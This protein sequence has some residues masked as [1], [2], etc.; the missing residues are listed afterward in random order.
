MLW[1]LFI[2]ALAMA[3][4]LPVPVPAGGTVLAHAALA[5]G[6]GVLAQLEEG[7]PLVAALVRGEVRVEVAIGPIERWAEYDHERRAIQV[8]P[9]LIGADLRTVAA[10]LAHEAT[11]A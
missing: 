10:L 4:V 7:R 9:S 8:H 3:Q 2:P 5:P 1:L 11:H 6:L